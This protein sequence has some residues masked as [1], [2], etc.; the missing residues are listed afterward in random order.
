MKIA[1]LSRAGASQDR[2]NDGVS[3]H[4]FESDESADFG[5]TA[6]PSLTRSV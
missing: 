5:P 2:W 4:L 6:D 1:M 3:S